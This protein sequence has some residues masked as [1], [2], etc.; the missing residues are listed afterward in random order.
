[1]KLCLDVGNT[2]I[3]GGVFKG[4]TLCLTFRYQSGAGHSSDQFGLFLRQV[5]RENTLDPEAV[6]HIAMCSVVPELDYSIASACIK[7]FKV[8]PFILKAGVKT[9]LNIQY[10]NPA[11]VGA[12]RIAN[13]IAGCALFPKRAKII[14]DFGTAT[15]LCA[16]SDD[17]AYLG[18]IIL[19]GLKLSMTALQS[20]T[21]KLSAVEILKPHAIVGRSTAQSIQSGLY[22]GHL[23]MIQQL[24]H[25]ISTEYFPG[26]DV[27]VIGTGGFAK[28]FQHEACFT[29]IV[30]DLVLQGL[31]LALEKNG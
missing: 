12:D 16:I 18:G 4:E 31:R 17:N 9:G 22:Y 13:A 26:Q 7:Y 11:E 19:A 21:S 30:P 24:S 5:L 2:Q 14:V 1:M 28:L 6:E 27:A 20:N 15:T 29:T 10:L 3:F 25:H 23:A 8:E